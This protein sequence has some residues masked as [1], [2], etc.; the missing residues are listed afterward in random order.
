MPEEGAIIFFKHHVL[1]VDSMHAM[2]AIV[3]KLHYFVI[4]QDLHDYPCFLKLSG[5]AL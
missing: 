2:G 3:N 5:S 4:A 1:P